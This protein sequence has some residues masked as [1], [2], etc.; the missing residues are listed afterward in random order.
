MPRKWIVPTLVLAVLV[1]GGAV[2]ALYGPQL[3]KF[4]LAL[5]GVHSE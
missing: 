2:I 1:V 3:Y 4:L 5:H